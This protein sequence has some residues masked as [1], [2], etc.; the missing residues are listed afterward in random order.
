ML[1]KRP[2]LCARAALIVVAGTGLVACNGCDEP[3]GLDGG[4]RETVAS[5]PS[6]PPSSTEASEPVPEVMPEPRC[7]PDM[8]KV[9]LGALDA[10]V[11]KL[12]VDRYEAMLVDTATSQR[13]PPYYTPS[14]RAAQQTAKMWESM[15]LT[16]GDPEARATPLPALPVWMIQ[17]DFEPRA[18]SRKDVTPN[19]HVSGEQAVVACRNAGKRLCSWQEWRTACGGEQNRKYPYGEAYEA[20][21]CNVFREAHPAMV[22]HD[23]PGIGHSD[24]RLN[25]VT[26]NGKPLLRKAGG[27]PGCTS[28]W[29]DDE[30]YDMVGNLDEWIDD[31]DG[32]FAGGFYARAT[33]DGCEWRGT[34]HSIDYADYSTGV[35]CCADLP[36]MAR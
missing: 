24:P 25:R 26:V 21:R 33:T 8:V 10:G 20:R 22:L 32:T 3:V 15:R 17:R 27:T 29:G 23:N 13:I 35:R 28:R 11:P 19:G 36:G 5:A 14:R 1:S 9:V 12:C 18:Q 34:A 7:P 16:M 31:P 30:I 2:F 4:D 6:D